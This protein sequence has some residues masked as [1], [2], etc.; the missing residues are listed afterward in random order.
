MT[1]TEDRSG[2]L[3]APAPFVSLETEEFWAATARGEL[4]L[5]RCDRCGSFIWYPRRFCPDC[6]SQDVS[7]VRASGRGTVYSFTIV[8]RGPGPYGAASPF[9]LAYVELEEG[10]R[11]MTNVVGCDP[12]AVEVGMPVEVVFHDTGEGTALFRFRPAA[13]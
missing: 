6:G 12:E 9:V 3:P 1:A 7:W 4:L 2:A 5:P 11:V 13:G 8:R 10:P